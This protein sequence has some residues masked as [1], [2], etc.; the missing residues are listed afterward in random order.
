[1][2]CTGNSLQLLVNFISK[3]K[4][5]DTICVEESASETDDRA[6]TVY[7]ELGV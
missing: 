4:V 7:T 2:L 1:M 6:A 5:P 3:Q